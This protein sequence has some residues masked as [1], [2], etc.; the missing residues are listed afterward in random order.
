MRITELPHVLGATEGTDRRGRVLRILTDLPLSPQA[1]GHNAVK[2]RGLRKAIERIRATEP[3]LK[4]DHFELTNE[5]LRQALHARESSRSPAR[6]LIGRH[7]PISSIVKLAFA[8][9]LDID[10][11]TQLAI[12]SVPPRETGTRWS[13]VGKS[14]QYAKWHASVFAFLWYGKSV[15]YINESRRNVPGKTS[16]FSV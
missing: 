4:F 15:G 9:F 11:D 2:L 7:H 5:G 1:L 10:V 8:A 3:Y 14:S 13:T 16:R 12:S 6:W